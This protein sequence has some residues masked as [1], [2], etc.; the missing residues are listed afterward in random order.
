MDTD[1]KSFYVDLMQEVAASANANGGFTRTTLVE[2]LANRLVEAEELQDWVPC[3]YEGR[4]SRNRIL[5]L[6]GYSTDELQVDGTLQVLVAEY[7]EGADYGALGTADIRAAFGRASAFVEDAKAGRL[8]EKIEP[9]TPAADLA[10]LIFDSQ[11]AVRTLRILVLSNATLGKGYKD[12]ERSSVDSMKA[13]LHIWDLVRFQRLASL[14]GREEIDLDITEFAPGGLPALPAGIGRTEY[15]AYLCVVPGTL[16]AKIYERYGSR[17]LEGNVRAFLSAR[18]NVNKGIRRTIRTEPGRFFAFNNGITATATK[19]ELGPSGS[20][21]RILDLQIVNGGQTTA[22]LYNTHEQDHASL[23]DIFVQMKLSVLPP[24][25]AEVMI[26]EISRYANTQNKVSEADL[27]A[28]HPFNRKVEELSRHAWAPGRT[29]G[30]MTHWFYERARA[31]YQTEQ[32]KLTAAQKRTFLS[33]NPKDQV[34]TKTDLAKFEN[35]WRR[36]PHI[37][38]EGAQK[39]FV[40]YAEAISEEYDSRPTEFNERWFQ[41]MVSKAILFKAA[42]RIVSGA[43]WYSGGYRANIVTYAVARLNQLIDD[44]F[45]GQVLNLD[46]I[47]REQRLADAVSAQLEETSKV[48]YAVL[49]SPPAGMKNVTEWAKRGRCWDVA[50]EAPVRVS[51]GLAHALKAADADE[52]DR[53]RARGEARDDEVINEAIEVVKLSESG[54]WVRALAS[55]EAKKVLSLTELGIMETAVKRGPQWVPSDAQAKRL[56]AAARKLWAEGTQ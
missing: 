35:T 55:K 40:K 44:R 13:E 33:Q 37:V 28:N 26:P 41:H 51:P 10:R 46:V 6:D 50:A 18:G 4:G 52:E 34:I 32:I 56:M 36:L 22:S 54:F 21:V 20:I 5:G 43:P 19:V 25:I 14:G 29:A 11:S 47:W 8:H 23:D 7:C 53:R 39:N 3:F 2:T 24:D 27:F 38:S 31:Q 48:V 1:L 16:L 49:V 17:I 9:S 30:Q 42:E 15:A 45:P 12:V